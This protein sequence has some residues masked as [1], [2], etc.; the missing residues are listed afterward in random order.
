MTADPEVTWG[1]VHDHLTAAFDAGRLYGRAEAVEAAA[2]DRAR[3][4]LLEQAGQWR[5][6]TIELASETGPHWARAMAAICDA[7]DDQD[8]GAA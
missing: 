6:L 7:D 8:E 5:R 1:E 2:E 3:E 4:L